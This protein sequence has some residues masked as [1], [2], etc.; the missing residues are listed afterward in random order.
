MSFERR[1]KRFYSLS[2]GVSVHE[3]WVRPSV[4]VVRQSVSLHSRRTF[5]RLTPQGQYESDMTSPAHQLTR[6]Q[7]D[8]SMEQYIAKATRVIVIVADVGVHSV[9]STTRRQND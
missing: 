2:T 5:D 8:E 9:T 6:T 4:R 3:L 1:L 7:I